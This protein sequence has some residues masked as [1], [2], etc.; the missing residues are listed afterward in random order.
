MMMA[1][2]IA[3]A[4]GAAIAASRSEAAPPTLYENARV[5]TGSGFA[6]RLLAV[7]DGRF[8]DPGSMPSDTQ[9]VD[10]RG[11][12]VVPAYANAHV[13]ATPADAAGSRAFTDAGVFYAWNPNTTV[14]DNAARAFWA[15]A[16]TYDVRVAQGGISEPDGHPEALYVDVLSRHFYGGRPRGWFVGNAYHYGRTRAEV[17]A[18]LDKLVLQKTDFVKAYLLHSEDHARRLGKK[19]FYGGRGMSPAMFA[20]LVRAAAVR[21]LR[22]TAHVETAAD[23]RLAATSGAHMAAHLPGYAGSTGARDLAAKTLTAADAALIARS[24]MLV[25]PTYGVIDGDPFNAWD[26]VEEKATAR[27][28]AVQADNVRLLHAAGARILIGTD[29]RAAI[30]LEVEHLVRIGALTPRDATGVALGTGAKLFPE[31]R[32]GCFE[33]GCEA[34]FLVLDADPTI[35]VRALRS[36]RQRVMAGAELAA[37]AP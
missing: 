34:D 36:I 4:A 18:A 28:L 10:L 29:G 30:T 33:A 37:P 14:V 20:Y 19:R 11:G 2:R 24:G 35:D 17:D 23:L 12:H 26:V 25:V 22:V 7:R 21:G 9:R 27:E 32:I 31:R 8:V 3:L 1:V 6:H 16:D 13:H 15:R 5:W